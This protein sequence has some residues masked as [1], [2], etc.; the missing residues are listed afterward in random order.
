MPILNSSRGSFVG[1]EVS[2]Y[3]LAQTQRALKSL[4]P[5]AE[6]ALSRGIRTALNKARDKARAR[7]PTTPP[8]SGW[9]TGAAARGRSRGGAGWPA[10]DASKARAGITV[11]RG[12]ARGTRRTSTLSVAWQLRSTDA[13]GTIFDKSA[14]SST[15]VG[16]Q[17][18]ANLDRAG[19]AQRVLWPAWLEEREDAMRTIEAEIHKAEAVVQ[20]LLDEVEGAA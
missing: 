5:E 8:M 1:V 11:G 15:P 3:G 4:A 20:R 10:W 14:N 2:V 12:A 6:K 17:F 16:A 13:A 7:I 9:R 19:R 18:I